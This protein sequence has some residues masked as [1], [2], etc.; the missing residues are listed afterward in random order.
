MAHSTTSL[1]CFP[2]SY[3]IEP[4]TYNP[5]VPLFRLFTVIGRLDTDTMQWV[6]KT[7]NLAGCKEY[8]PEIGTGRDLRTWLSQ[9]SRGFDPLA[10]MFAVGPDEV[11]RVRYAG[12]VLDYVA[13]RLVADLR[14]IVDPR[15]SDRIFDRV[16]DC[17]PGWVRHLGDSHAVNKALLDAFRSG[18]GLWTLFHT[19]RRSTFRALCRAFRDADPTRPVRVPLPEDKEDPTFRDLDDELRCAL[20]TEVVGNYVEDFAR[21]KLNADLAWKHLQ[22]YE[23][24]TKYRYERPA[25]VFLEFRYLA[26]GRLG[27]DVVDLLAKED[28]AEESRAKP[29]VATAVAAPATTPTKSD[30]PQKKATLHLR[31]DAKQQKPTSSGSEPNPRAEHPHGKE[32]VPHEAKLHLRVRAREER[33]RMKAKLRPSTASTATATATAAATTTAPQTVTRSNDGGAATE[34]PP[35]APCAKRFKGDEELSLGKIDG[36]RMTEVYNPAVDR[37]AGARGLWDVQFQAPD[38]RSELDGTQ[39]NIV[40]I[41]QDHDLL[42]EPTVMHVFV[43]DAD[44][45]P[46][47]TEELLDHHTMFLTKTPLLSTTRNDFPD[48]ED[49]AGDAAGKRKRVTSALTGKTVSKATDR[50]WIGPTPTFTHLLYTA[51]RPCRIA[52]YDADTKILVHQLDYAAQLREPLRVR[53]AGVRFAIFLGSNIRE[54]VD[55]SAIRVSTETVHN[56][57]LEVE[58]RGGRKSI[59]LLPEGGDGEES[60]SSSSSSS[61]DEREEKESDD[62]EEEE[63]DESEEEGDS[64]DME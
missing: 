44:M 14:T 55:V 62:E 7:L 33:T 49:G 56:Y 64:S 25:D 43:P 9:A 27:K 42:G 50:R 59:N 23:E 19:S 30:T 48:W 3:K 24:G 4:H 53:V 36:Q 58:G 13:T 41:S 35:Q 40:M 21:E 17:F 22:D 11:A 46:R 5:A 12:A 45:T 32:R 39:T 10:P 2:F 28:A 18:D 26:A 60:S 34:L 52:F 37:G 15:D 16:V 47:W 31:R 54:Q 61:G 1:P 63:E 8:P 38:E 29:A 6:S 20:E 51:F 57:N